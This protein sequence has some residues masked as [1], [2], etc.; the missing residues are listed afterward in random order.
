M[1]LISSA[2]AVVIACSDASEGASD[3]TAPTDTGT[4]ADADALEPTD[5]PTSE[6]ED[7]AE[8]EGDVTL[9]T[10][11][12]DVPTGPPPPPSA[13]RAI[14]GMSMGA[15]AITIALRHPGTFGIVGALGG[16]P[17][18]TYM[19]A[20]MLR[21]QLAGFCPYE[22][23]VARLDA[24]DDASADPPVTCGPRPGLSPLE[25]AQDFNHLH[26]DDNGITMTRGF[27]ADVIDNFSTAYG[28]LAS[29]EHPLSPLLP[30]GVD[31]TWFRATPDH[32]RCAAL[33]A[34]PR[35]HAINAE[36]NPRGEHPV[37]PLCDI[38]RPVTPGL[39]PSWF[40]PAAPRDVPIA[41]LLAIDLNGNGRRDLGEPLMLNPWERFADVG[42]DGCAN[43]RE[44]G[45]GGCLEAAPRLLPL[46]PGD[47]NGDDYDWEGNPD[48]TEQNDK[49]D[50]GE[51][52]ADLGLDGVAASDDAT[53]PI[54]AD[55]GEGN[56]TW[57]AVP[58]FDALLAG[59]ADTLIRTLD[60]E[61]L[62]A[63]D[64]WLDAGIRDALNAG[65]VARNL[66]A[67]LRSRGRPVSVYHG[68]SGRPG[69]LVPDLPAGDLLP[70]VFARDMS[71]GA[72]GR[73]VYVE[74]GKFDATPEEIADGDG[75]HVGSATD[76]LER[77]GA[78]ITFAFSRLPDPDLE[79]A[80]FPQ[81]FARMS[82][83]HSPALGGRR[84]FTIGLPPGYDL[85][86]N[87]DKRYPVVFFL[88]G[89]GQEASDLGPA[90]LA[91][92]AFMSEGQVPKVI[93]VF[94]DG[95]CCFVD[96]DTGQRE[97]ACRPPDDGVRACLDPA[98]EGPEESCTFREIP[99]S[100]LERECQRGS[101]YIDLRSD[102]WGNPRSDMGYATS[103]IELVRH[104][105][106]T[107]RTRS[108]E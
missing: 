103:I 60:A 7:D 22:D 61:A 25:P 66:V 59:D 82:S 105:D 29:P 92:A 72:I 90:A 5:V 97:C 68:F 80:P 107:Y 64:F 56:G 67:A 26:F 30:A 15:S 45:A 63:M 71:P 86:E 52:F 11:A 84:G 79:L 35:A 70:G 43:A 78:F 96:R 99:E 1:A 23:L 44:D 91:T 89:I 49:Y 37:I 77:L 73:D 93:M 18:A 106:A 34:I 16:Y 100:R 51:P 88:H 24:L 94:P 42:V 83:F 10:S 108:S 58:A 20:Q 9:D 95:A 57:D 85:P 31:P 13:H 2:L 27:Y 55:H 104:V 81:E 87:A 8:I 48:G 98:C 101:L 50:V 32:A 102:R 38:N 65:V 40:D 69:S 36:H 33:P 54:A 76:A 39:P 17:D 41:A 46:P 12:P 6:V 28:N 4:T 53:W 62:D 47:P 75:K 3:A 21:L 14:G 19:M 74:Y